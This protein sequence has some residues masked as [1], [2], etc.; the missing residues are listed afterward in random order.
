MFG[1]SGLFGSVRGLH[2]DGLCPLLLVPPMSNENDA[3]LRDAL[4]GL[5][6]RA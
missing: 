6:G 1:G 4:K 5:T 2:F 3:T